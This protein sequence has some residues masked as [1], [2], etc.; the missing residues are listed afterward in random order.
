[1]NLPKIYNW[2]R[3]RKNAEKIIKELGIDSL[4]YC[5]ESC[6]LVIAHKDN[7]TLTEVCFCPEMIDEWEEAENPLF[8]APQTCEANQ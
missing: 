4:R 8:T 3:Q 1:M 2:V 6:S 7:K 5:F